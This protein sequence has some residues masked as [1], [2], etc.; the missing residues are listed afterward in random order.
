MKKFE[1]RGTTITKGMD[2]EG[3]SLGNATYFDLAIILLDCEPKT[4]WT[5]SIMA[6]R[7]RVEDKIR[8][9]EEGETVDLEDAEFDKIVE[10]L[11]TMKWK[12]KHRDIVDFD[13]YVRSI[14]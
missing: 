10:Q 3:K 1:N 13:Q 2:N 8:D 14:K 4:G 12:M 7:Y 6:E 5:P 9:I 11:D